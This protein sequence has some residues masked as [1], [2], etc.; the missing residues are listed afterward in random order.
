MSTASLRKDHDLIEKVI[1]AMESTIQLL[2]DGK[3]IPESILLPV[4][5]FS[6]NF[7]DVCHHSK[8]E[9]SLFPALEQA[10]M[11]TNMGPIAMMLID[12]QRSR[13]LGK[14]MESS[15]KTYLSSGDSTKL[16]TDLQQYVE[17]ITEHLWKENNRLF[18]M[19]EARLQYV[20]KKINQE[21]NDIEESKLRET[22]KTREHYEQL[23]ETLTRDV[24]KQGN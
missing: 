13:E 23:A 8:E 22:G 16:V 20:S 5:D 21:L 10:G 15:A 2:K 17:H 6:K 9:K 7:T 12:H 14:E 11:P 18:M 24:S 19:A 3:Q 4:I 1:K